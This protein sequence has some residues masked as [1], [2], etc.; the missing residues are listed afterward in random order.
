MSRKSD[1]HDTLVEEWSRFNSTWVDSRAA[2]KDGV[3][4]RFET[5][6]ITHFEAEVPVFLRSLEQLKIELDAARRELR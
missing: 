1:A 3:A 4:H 5:Q 6:F 2:W